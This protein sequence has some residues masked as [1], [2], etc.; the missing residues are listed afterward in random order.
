MSKERSSDIVEFE[1]GGKKVWAAR[2]SKAH[3]KHVKSQKKAPA[4]K[5]VDV[6][7]EP[8]KK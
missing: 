8:D 5:T 2:D 3:Q 1:V 7:T 4:V 6:K